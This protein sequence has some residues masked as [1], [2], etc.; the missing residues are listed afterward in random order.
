MET[1]LV[2][3]DRQNFNTIYLYLIVSQM[4]SFMTLARTNIFIKNLQFKTDILCYAIILIG[5]FNRKR[6]L[7]KQ[8]GRGALLFY[9]KF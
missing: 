1:K 6:E 2:Y 5:A 9:Q 7:V 4:K 3:G 8:Q